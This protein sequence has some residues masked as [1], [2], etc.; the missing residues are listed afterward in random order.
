[1]RIGGPTS[2]SGIQKRSGAKGT[3]KSGSTFAPTSGEEAD[4][5]SVSGGVS[6]TYA[7]DAL[8]SLQEVEDPLTGKR[9]GATKRGHDLLDALEEM[10]AD[11][12]A[13]VMPEA[14]LDRILQLVQTRLPS[15]DPRLEA[16]ID[17]IDLRAR[18]ELAKLGRFPD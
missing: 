7:V 12:L 16:V 5:S 14:R 9:R 10:K 8:L 15:G 18:V 6:S 13:G 2:G 17:E 4:R 1:M 3:S 11:L